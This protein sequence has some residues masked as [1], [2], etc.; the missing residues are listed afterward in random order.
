MRDL[1]EAVHACSTLGLLAGALSSA[2][3]TAAYALILRQGRK[4]RVHGMPL[5]ALGANLSWEI[6]FLAVTLANRA[7]DVRLAMLLPWTVLDVGIV[8]Q[9]LRYGRSDYTDPLVVRH[10]GKGLAAILA[11]SF[12]VLLAFVLE[13]RDAIGWY[14][15]FGQN[16]MM[17]ALFIAMLLRRGD[18][19]G[20]SVPIAVTK[21]LGTFFAF[22]LAL[23][24]SP[25][26]LHE[27]WASLLPDRYHPISPLIVVLYSVIFVLD[28]AYI[29][30]LRARGAARE[31]ARPDAG[32]PAL[33]DGQTT[34]KPRWR[35]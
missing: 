16:L 14:A 2:F 28:V 11:L 26:S 17:S 6:I 21:A 8:I 22:V 29:A 18:T 4:D 10:F 30:L 13:M 7:Y 31:A 23:F 25:P 34:G 27:H 24:W 19:R 12:A 1:F 33:G 9:C 5:V 32:A 15:A 20:Q 35:S 3:W